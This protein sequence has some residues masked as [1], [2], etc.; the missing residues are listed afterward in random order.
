[1][2]DL[3]RNG[4]V[5]AG[6]T[7]PLDATDDDT[8]PPTTSFTIGSPKYV[9]AL[10]NV[11]ITSSTPLTLDAVDDGGI[12][13]ANT[14]YRIYNTGYDSGW[15]V[16]APPIIFQITGLDDCAYN[17]DY[18]S[19]DKSGNVEST[20]TNTVILDNTPP[21]TTLTIGSPQYTDGG[22]TYVTSST[23]F[24]LAASDGT[25]SGV[26]S[27]EYRIN[28]GSWTPYTGAF[29]L[30]G[31]DGI[32]VI[33]YRSTDNLGTVE[34]TNSETVTLDNTSPSV[35]VVA[36]PDGYVY[37]QITIQIDAADA[38][39][40]VDYVEYSL[41]E[42]TWIPTT[43]NSVTGYYEADWDTSLISEG[44]YTVH[45]RAFDH[46]GNEGSDP[47]PPEVT[48]V[49]LELSTSF[50]DSDFNPIEEFS[51]IFSAQKPPMYKLSTN[52]GTFYEIIEITNTGSTVT[53]P[54]LMLDIS[55]PTEAD[56][57]GPDEP[58]FKLI[59]AKPVRIYLNGA[60]VTPAGR[61]LPDL[62]S[63]LVGQ[64]L[65]PGDTIKITIHYEYAFKGNSYSAAEIDG[66][67][68]EDYIFETTIM[69]AYG[70]SWTGTL[71]ANAVI[72]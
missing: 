70:P 44:D 32:Y 56:F 57:L 52:P 30:L 58:A 35:E 37:G 66:W 41:D 3:N 11:Y 1:M 61:W 14:R 62:S 23:P 10:G 69:N 40:G 68:G 63:L 20:N 27:T 72:E 17:I 31:P 36:P 16:S 12:G 22:D 4:R 53:L 9:D 45:A 42:S 21:A 67:T 7:D 18:Y 43:F 71:T 26:A 33:D 6:E 54:S 28:L 25:G 38:G 2:E 19:T 64:A 60:D 8:T 29:T 65:S 15:I 50:T 39:S 34:P 51:A 49:H 46:L 59:G 48:V 55:I 13:V 47:E 24:T 5:D